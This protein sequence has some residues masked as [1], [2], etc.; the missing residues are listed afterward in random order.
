MDLQP[1]TLLSAGPRAL[2]PVP[3]AV[4]E[5]AGRGA[6]KRLPEILAIMPA[7]PI[8]SPLPAFSGHSGKLNGLYMRKNPLPG[9][10]QSLRICRDTLTRSQYR[11]AG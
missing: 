6:C 11:T 3:Q 2:A 1:E 8:G 4:A 7:S 10:N 5:E 9:L